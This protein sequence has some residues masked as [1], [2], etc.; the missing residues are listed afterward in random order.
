MPSRI[1]IIEIYPDY[2]EN[3]AVNLDLPYSFGCPELDLMGY[4][5]AY[6]L[7]DAIR[8]ALKEKR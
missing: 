6:S 7:I 3:G 8:R 5:N 1:A 2:D 4:S